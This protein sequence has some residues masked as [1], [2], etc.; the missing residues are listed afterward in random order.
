[1]RVGRRFC[2]SVLPSLRAGVRH[3]SATPGACCGVHPK[4]FRPAAGGERAVQICG[5]EPIAFLQVVQAQYRLGAASVRFAGANQSFEGASASRQREDCRDRA[6]SGLR[7]SG[8]LYNG[9]WELCGHDTPPISAFLGPRSP[10][11]VQSAAS[12]CGIGSSASGWRVTDC[13]FKRAVTKSFDWIDE[14]RTKVVAG[15][16][17]GKEELERTRDRSQSK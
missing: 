10:C 17:N 15:V 2:P 8:A 4:P 14:A 16:E 6:W 12:R 3:A 13:S 7:E 11:D 9:V 1:M 5:D